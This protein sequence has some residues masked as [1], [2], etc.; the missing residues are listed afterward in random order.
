MKLNSQYS[1]PTCAELATD[2]ITHRTMLASCCMVTGKQVLVS[3]TQTLHAVTCRLWTKEPAVV[4]SS[5]QMPQHP[6]QDGTVGHQTSLPV[7]EEM[8]GETL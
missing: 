4:D 3:I 2:W 5:G 6:Q 1:A 7:A 8:V